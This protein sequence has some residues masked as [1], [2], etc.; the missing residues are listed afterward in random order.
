VQTDYGLVQVKITVAG[1]RIT[2]VRLAKLTSPDPISAQ[3]NA[4]AAPILIRQTMQAQSAHI[5]GVSGASYTSAGYV[6]SLQ[7]ALDRAGLD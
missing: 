2:A 7:A 5:D 1:S 4:Q 6:Q 3:I